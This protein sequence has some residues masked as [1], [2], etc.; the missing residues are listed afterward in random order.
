[1]SVVIANPE[2]GTLD[3]FGHGEHKADSHYPNAKNHAKKCRNGLPTAS[4]QFDVT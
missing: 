1:M 3:H 2:S 4:T